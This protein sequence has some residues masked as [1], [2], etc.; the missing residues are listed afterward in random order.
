MDGRLCVLDIGGENHDTPREAAE[1]A[2]RQYAEIAHSLDIDAHARR[3]LGMF[4][5][6]AHAKAKGGFIDDEP[7]E[8]DKKDGNI[9]RGII[10]YEDGFADY[11]NFV[12]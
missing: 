12:E 1:S 11:G 7:G 8:Q 2:G 5:A 6:G 4:A 9:D 3:R 10:L